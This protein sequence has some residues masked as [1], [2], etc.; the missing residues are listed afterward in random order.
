MVVSSTAAYTTR[1]GDDQ[2]LR[3]LR[4]PGPRHPRLHQRRA[5]AG[6]VAAP[7]GDRPD[8]PPP[9]PGYG[10][11]LSR[12]ERGDSPAADDPGSPAAD[13]LV[14]RAGATGPAGGGPADGGPAGSPAGPGEG[15]NR[16]SRAGPRV[17]PIAGQVRPSSGRPGGDRSRLRGGAAAPARTGPA[18]RGG[19]CPTATGGAVVNPQQVVD[20]LNRLADVLARNNP[21]RGNVELSLHIDQICCH[22]D[23]RVVVRTC[24]LGA[25]AGTIDLLAGRAVGKTDVPAPREHGR[26]ATPRRRA[27]GGSTVRKR[28]RKGFRSRPSRRPTWTGL[29]ASVR[30]CFGRTPCSSRARRA[31]RRSRRRRWPQSNERRVGRSR[32]WRHTSAGASRPSAWR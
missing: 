2:A 23:G 11:D 4:L 29:P 13:R 26:S 15:V 20:R 8:R 10:R 32:S 3:Q 6:G 9:I 27:R 18:P 19:R 31:G 22:D 17:V 28:T 24:K 16:P 14:Q 30:S 5:G 1:A 21:T 7:G 12:P 25:L